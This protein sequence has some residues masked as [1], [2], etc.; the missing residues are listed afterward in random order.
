MTTIVGVQRGYRAE[1]G[2]EF[3]ENDA[4]RPVGA[5]VGNAR[6]DRS[7]SGQ[8][9]CTGPPGLSDSAAYTL[10]KLDNVRAHLTAREKTEKRAL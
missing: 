8:S 3:P 5:V 10:G 2:R 7:E 1:S 9:G 6:A 4:A